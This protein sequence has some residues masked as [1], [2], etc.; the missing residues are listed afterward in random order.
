[1]DQTTAA[2]GGLA[3]GGYLIALFFVFCYKTGVFAS[4]GRKP[5]DNKRFLALSAAAFV[6]GVGCLAS[7]Y[8]GTIDWALQFP[9]VVAFVMATVAVTCRKGLML[10]E[11]IA[12]QGWTEL[13]ER[14]RLASN[15]AQI[16]K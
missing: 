10:L 2:I 14:E 11:T 4:F 9:P 5:L 16:K 7:I 13:Q 3:V 1:M 12:M 8:L 6:P 15:D